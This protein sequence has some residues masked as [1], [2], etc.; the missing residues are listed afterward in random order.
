MRLGGLK[1]KN[2][3]NS[4]WKHS[5]NHHEGKLKRE[6]LEM[7]V[8]ETHR[9]P[10]SRQIH[11]GVA[12][13]TNKADIVM[14]SKSEWNQAR[15]PRIIIESGEEVIEDK[16]SGL[17]RNREEGAAYRSKHKLHIKRSN[18]QKRGI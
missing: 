10:L 1:N 11:E 13:E 14:N 17:N 3:K 4:L 8:V 9:S 16:E 2:E 12:I 18:T 6:D 15:L 5:F 7:K